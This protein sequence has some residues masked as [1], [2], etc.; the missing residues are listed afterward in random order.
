MTSHQNPGS[1]LAPPSATSTD[2]E[3]A[4]CRPSP[5]DLGA[6]GSSLD[7]APKMGQLQ[8][9]ISLLLEDGDRFMAKWTVRFTAA[10]GQ[11]VEIDAVSVGTV[12]TVT[13]HAACR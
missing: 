2:W 11:A 4:E 1:Q 7:E 8:D 10:S 12:K 13:S 9:E 3:S 5:G 6:P